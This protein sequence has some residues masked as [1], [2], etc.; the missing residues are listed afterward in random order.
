M[1][2]FKINNIKFN[3]TSF[4][5]SHYNGDMTNEY[6]YYS[7]E[8]F[9]IY[10][11]YYFVVCNNLCFN[12]GDYQVYSMHSK[13]IEKHFC[14]NDDNFCCYVNY[15]ELEVSNFGKYFYYYSRKNTTVCS[16]KNYDKAF[17]VY[18]KL[19]LLI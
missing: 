12:V 13:H 10:N 3:L 6:E 8:V 9:I 4:N 11:Q 19:Q 1:K 5:R 2:S 15:S 18:T 14:I 17:F 7:D 16:I